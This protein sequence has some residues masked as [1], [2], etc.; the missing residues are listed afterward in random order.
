MGVIVTATNVT[1]V[2]QKTTL[3][4]C[5][6][7]CSASCGVLIAITIKDSLRDKTILAETNSAFTLCNNI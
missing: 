7:I 2:L 3:A 5:Y 1:R 4:K 6:N